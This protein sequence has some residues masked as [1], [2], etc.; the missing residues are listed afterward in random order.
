MRKQKKTLDKS[1]SIRLD[2]EIHRKLKEFAEKERRS[3]GQVIRIA[4]ENFL[5][6]GSEA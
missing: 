3:M 4:L 1:L 2:A 5:R 6:K